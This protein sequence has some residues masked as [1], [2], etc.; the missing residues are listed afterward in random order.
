MDTDVLARIAAADGP[1]VSLYLDSDSKREDAAPRYELNWKNLLRELE[2]LGVDEA[3][4]QAV[5]AARGEHSGGGT[6]VIIASRGTVHLATSLPEPPPGQV[7]RY[8]PLPH[9]LPLVEHLQAQLPHVVVITDR[10]GADVLGYVD[11][12][13]P[14]EAESVDSRRHPH[15]KTGIGGWAARRFEE[16]VHNS[17][18]QSAKD[19]SDVV[20]RV[21]KDVD[22]Q[23]L[24]IGGDVHATRILVEELPEELKP[25]VE[26]I[27][28]SRAADGDET[29]IAQRVLEVVGDRAGREV[30]SLLEDF[31]KYRGRKHKHPDGTTTVA[32]EGDAQEPVPAAINAADGLVE[33]VAALR[34][35]QVGTLLLSD[36]MP[37]DREVFVG[38]APLQL[39]LTGDEVRAFGV[40]DP[41][42]A[43]LV[44]A[45]TRAA[46]GAGADVR[47]VPADT[48]L[49]PAD[50][51]GALLRYST[52]VS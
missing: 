48:E 46:F 20:T 10:Q 13:Y 49:S 23:L 2:E 38:P 19:V 30:V 37:A 40:D 28:A 51:V 3:T 24:V 1:F 16:R 27:Q 36:M 22:A 35:A 47:I 12:P 11:E 29:L 9:L 18:E 42:T 33:T 52:P 39:G 31:A 4:R 32:G 26:L 43:P 50:G 5:S 41:V 34:Q 17:W 44:D 6:R 14:A 45:L 8:G 21:A 7:V 25:K 15:H